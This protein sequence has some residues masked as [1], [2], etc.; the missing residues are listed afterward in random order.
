MGGAVAWLIQP[1]LLSATLLKGT[2]AVL[3]YTVNDSTTQLLYVPVPAH[4][5][6]RAKAVIDG[7]VR[8]LAIGL[9]GA[10]L[11]WV[12]P[13]LPGN[14]LG[15]LLLALV[16]V[17]VAVSVA[18]RSEYLKALA[19]TLHH[20]RY[21]FDLD[22]PIPD[23]NI[24]QIMRR[25]FQ[26]SDEQQVLQ[27]LEMTRHHTHVDWSED[28][29]M[30]ANHASPAVRACAL[31]LVGERG[32]PKDAPVVLSHLN[33]SN[34]LVQAAAV[35]AY[36]AIGKERA[37]PMINRFLEQPELPVRRAAVI[38][39]IR[40]GGLDGVLSSAER[41]KAMLQSADA[42][43]REA[44]AYILGEIRVKNFYHPL[45]ALIVD[46]VEKVQIAAIRAAATI[47]TTEL[48]P[49]LVYRLEQ[50]ATRTEASEA[51]SAF[52]ASALTVLRSVLGNQQEALAIRLAVPAIL[53]KVGDPAA[54]EILLAQVDN[55]NERLRSR[56][57]ESIHGLR[58]H[59]PSLMVPYQR[60]QP[61]VLRELTDLY[62][63]IFV[64]ERLDLPA[65]ARL[66]VDALNQR[67]ERGLRRIFCL[68]GCIVPV[69]TIDVVY[70]IITAP[71]SSLRA[72]AIELLDNLLN[73]ELKRL[74]L[75]LL[76]Q[77]ARAA[78]EEIGREVVDIE[79]A[80]RRQWLAQLLMDHDP[81]M[82][83]C[84]LHAVVVLNERSL[85][86][87]VKGCVGAAAPIVRET[88]LWALFHLLPKSEVITTAISHL[89]DPS[90]TVSAYAAWL[91]D[92]FRNERA[93]DP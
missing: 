7:M 80:D 76:D 82:V 32:M 43:E 81:W 21:N 77:H 53:A 92:R 64:C 59:H 44:S 42:D 5:R 22:S 17:W 55:H 19:N 27:A 72:N 70:N 60:L 28:F 49:A 54:L 20:R 87:T 79:L 39:L 86:P 35:T 48:L 45:L 34:I 30:L 93:T 90:A 61:V 6:G 33:D 84:A 47:Q 10:L 37:I 74:L 29:Y 31:A 4:W 78:R 15:W 91:M 89:T 25:A 75:P 36:C 63:H 24:A 46:P 71:A 52:G 13:A 11:A 3:R 14:A 85:I 66:L 88:A 1:K 38:G 41:L 8:P 65:Q 68:L 40:Y 56:V 83:V 16:L 57:L 51:L 50:A 58:A 67:F 23:Q 18:V 62:R 26:D 69:Q 2:D 12:V 73:Q 9:S